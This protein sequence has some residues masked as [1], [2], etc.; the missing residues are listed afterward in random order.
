VDRHDIGMM[1]PSVAPM[2]LMFATIN[3]RRREQDRPFVPT[4]VLAAGY[5]IA[6]GAFRVAATATEWGLE[7]ATL[8]SPKMVSTNPVLGGLLFIAAG[9]CQWTP[10]KRAC[11]RNCR[12]PLSFI[13]TRWR[14]GVRAQP[15]GQ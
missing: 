3:R 5:L 6:W 10:L 14:D 9:V 1:V 13:M 12:S 11:L 7:A 2:I 4:A 8:V 15:R